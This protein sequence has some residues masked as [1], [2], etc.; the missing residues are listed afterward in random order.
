[1]PLHVPLQHEA[2]AAPSAM[3]G[4]PPNSVGFRPPGVQQVPRFPT[5]LLHVAVQH[6][7]FVP[8]GLGPVQPSGASVP[9]LTQHC[10]H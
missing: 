6:A 5:K 4:D 2:L 9:E 1:M 10:V 8:V 3:H 7:A